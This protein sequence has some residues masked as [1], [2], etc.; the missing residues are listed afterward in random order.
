MTFTDG[1]TYRDSVLTCDDIPLTD[2]LRET[3]TPV[4]IYSL[5]AVLDRLE[6]HRNAFAGLNH[7]VCYAVKAN[8]SLPLLQVLAQAK[9]G[10][11]VNS[12]GELF[13]AL[14]AGADPSRIIM[15]GVGKSREDI[16]DGLAA[17]IGWF[18]AESAS[19]CRL[20]SE[21]ASAHG[22]T[23]TLLLRLNP[24]VDA[25]THPYI[26]TGESDHKFGLSAADIRSLA[27]QASWLPGV[28]IGGLAFHLGSQIFSALPYREALRHLMRTLEDITPLLELQHPVIDIGGGFGVPYEEDGESLDPGIIAE[29]LLDLL[30]PQSDDVTLITEP[31]RSLVANAGI[32]VSTVEHVK[33]AHDR[34]FLVLDAGMND[35]LRPALYNADHGIVPLRESLGTVTVFYDVVGPVCE[36]SD[37]FARRYP[38]PELDRGDTVALLSAGA[39]GASMSSTYNSRPLAPEVVVLNGRW[40]LARERQPL[41]DLLRGERPFTAPEAPRA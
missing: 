33:P 24:D 34:I 25:G 27:A 18:N 3:K 11:D 26:S 39:Y 8:P 20:I 16:E 21:I 2:I 23:A 19:E 32:L 13:R 28:H 37:T 30:G 22:S 31:G 35:L 36:S 15:T 17:G 29:M 10:F 5:R 6:Q 12:R 38:L 14:R 41:E 9:A 40:H 4:Y 1:F 7:H